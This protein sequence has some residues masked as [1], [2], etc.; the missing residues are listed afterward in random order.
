MKRNSLVLIAATAITF[1]TVPI[2][3]QAQRYF[4]RSNTQ[5]AVPQS[6]VLSGTLGRGYVNNGVRYQVQRSRYG[7]SQAYT[8]GRQYV[9]PGV[10]YTSPSTTYYR[11]Q[12]IQSFYGNSYPSQT[13]YGSSYPSQNYF[14][15]SGYVS[16]SVTRYQ[17]GYGTGYYS[18]PR[19]ASNANA[20]AIIGGVIGG[21]E[22]AQ[23]GSIIGGSIHP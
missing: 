8:N 14:G 2:E 1:L 13:H 20:G 12:P 4:Y 17:S 16:P 19:Q 21:N 22:G 11:S 10:T 5:Q 3:A 18:T 7:T 6:R 9:Q 15:I 23:V